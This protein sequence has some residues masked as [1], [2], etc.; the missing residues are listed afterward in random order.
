MDGTFLK[1][2][3]K[4]QLLVAIGQDCMN[5]FY[6]LTWVVVDK[7]TSRTWG[8][9]LECLKLYLELNDGQGATFISDMQ[10]GLIDAV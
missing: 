9:F 6:P 3:F 5:Q 8:W 7:E 10:K 2:R 4:G 1:G